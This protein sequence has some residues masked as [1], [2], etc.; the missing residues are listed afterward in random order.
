M[1]CLRRVSSEKLTFIQKLKRFPSFLP[2]H[3][4]ISVEMSSASSDT[5]YAMFPLASLCFIQITNPPKKSCWADTLITLQH[6]PPTPLTYTH[7]SHDQQ[8]CCCFCCCCHPAA[9]LQQQ[10][11]GATCCTREWEGAPG[12]GRRYWTTT[13]HFWLGANC[14]RSGATSAINHPNIKRIDAG[15]LVPAHWAP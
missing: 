8:H 12:S 13:D 10:Q 1:T 7:T 3:T 9:P 2:P 11:R 15:C 14:R 6:L 4:P 5:A